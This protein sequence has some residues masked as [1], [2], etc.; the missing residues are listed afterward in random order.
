MPVFKP[1]ALDHVVLR[2]KDVERSLAFYVDVL[3]LE[4]LRV[5]EWQTGK[6][7]FPSVR[8]NG[9]TIMDLFPAEADGTNVDHICIV[10][11]TFDSNEVV[12]ALPGARF[13]DRLFGARGY[14]D[15]VYVHDP[16]GNVI[17]LRCY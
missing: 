10:V 6:A 7:P 14:A 13:N 5:E 17:E 1:V 8:I 16:D 11:E 9:S 3:G 12:A 15:S 4:P 2:S